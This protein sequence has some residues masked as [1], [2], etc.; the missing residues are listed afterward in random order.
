MMTIN[1]RTL[2]AALTMG[3]LS[4]L[5]TETGSAQGYNYG[6]GGYNYGGGGYG[7]GVGGAVP[8]TTFKP[9]QYIRGPA[10]NGFNPTTGSV[11]LQGQAVYKN[12][13]QYQYIGRGYYQDPISGNTYNPTTR[14]YTQG[15]NVNFESTNYI[16]T[17]SGVR[18]DPL[19]GSV[20]VPGQVVHRQTGTYHHIGNGYYRNP[21][22][23][24]VYNPTTGVYKTPR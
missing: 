8:H 9:G 16:Q 2:A 5:V 18:V 4:L 19:K 23:G 6:G 7:G 3:A 11:H 15:K 1:A 20:H 12:G 22:T 21:V 17:G 10:G 24:R 14:S 13:R